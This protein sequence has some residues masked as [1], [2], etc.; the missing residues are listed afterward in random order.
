[1]I[2]RFKPQ[3]A[4]IALLESMRASVNLLAAA[5][6]TNRVSLYTRRV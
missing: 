1:M 3:R 6:N 5:D 4:Q 2:L